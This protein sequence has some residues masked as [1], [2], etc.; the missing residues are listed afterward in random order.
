MRDPLCP[1][2]IYLWHVIS[3]RLGRKDKIWSRSSSLRDES[4]SILSTSF[5]RA[6]LA[7]GPAV[8]LSLLHRFGILQ[9]ARIILK[10]YSRQHKDFGLWKGKVKGNAYVTKRDPVTGKIQRVINS[11]PVY[12]TF[13]SNPPRPPRLGLFTWTRR[14]HTFEYH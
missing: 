7:E 14:S 11:L 8:R 6:R 3:D 9:I 2:S 10:S 1:I 5:L 12:I 13:L 4:W